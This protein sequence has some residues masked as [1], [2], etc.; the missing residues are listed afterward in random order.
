MKARSEMSREMYDFIISVKGDDV[1]ALDALRWNVNVNAR[2]IS[3]K[4]PL[5][6]ACASGSINALRYLLENGADPR[7]RNE[8]TLKT[9]LMYASENGRS[10]LIAGLVKWGVPINAKDRCGET[11]FSLAVRGCFV[12]AAR[13]LL[14]LGADPGCI[15]VRG[16]TPVKRA[17]EEGRGDLLSMLKEYGQEPDKEE[18]RKV[19]LIRYW[20]GVIENRSRNLRESKIAMKTAYSKRH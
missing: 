14:E 13:R 3:G 1:D 9:T 10:N 19:N 7:I 15:N 4:T 5:M 6:Y 20:E 16:M 8:R 2:D 11:A 17:L 12:K 18:V